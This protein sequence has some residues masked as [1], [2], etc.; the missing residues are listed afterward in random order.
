MFLVNDRTDKLWIMNLDNLESLRIKDA[1]SNP[2]VYIVQCAMVSGKRVDVFEGTET[3][4]AAMVRILQGL[5]ITNQDVLQNV[6]QMSQLI[7]DA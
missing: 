4:C 1:K 2:E 6:L 7:P 3:E 5:L